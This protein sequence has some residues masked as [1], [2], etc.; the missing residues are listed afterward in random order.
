MCVALG[1]K[2]TPNI[3]IDFVNADGNVLIAQSS[4]HATSTSLV[5]FLAELDIS[6][7]QER[8]G[9]V[10]DH[11]N[12]DTVSASEKHDV[13]VLDAPKPVRA[14]VNPLFSLND[15]DV[16]ALP[17]TVG[18]TLGSGQ[19][20]TPILRAP[21]TAYSYNP[22]EQTDAVDADDLFAVG[23]Q[24]S[25][26]SAFQARNSARVTLLGSAEMLQDSWIE[27]KVARNGE[28]KAAAANR[29]FGKAL[30]GWTFQEI[31]VLRV[32]EIEHRLK[33]QNETNPEIYRI[34]NDV[35]S[36]LSS[37]RERRC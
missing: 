29:A 9:L 10:V 2:L 25:L 6:L 22:K 35:V 23:H 26:V 34:K 24:V 17:H 11:F 27:S 36:L 3:L 5:Q 30:S 13:L 15:G 21:A 1:A 20:L 7:P 16:L 19:L 8:T 33:G 37:R 31:G 4:T 18:H 32:N 12:Y 14:G 28:K